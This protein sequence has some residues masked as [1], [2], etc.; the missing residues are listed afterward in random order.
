MGVKLTVVA[1]EG[2]A[3]IVCSILRTEGIR[4]GYR[5]TDVSAESGLDFGGW[6]EILVETADETRAR[7]ILATIK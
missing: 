7:E 6:R 4:C 1:N 3:E 2:E 5:T